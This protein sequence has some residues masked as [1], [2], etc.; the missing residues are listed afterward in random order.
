[1]FRVS[2]STLEQG[3]RWYAA[4]ETMSVLMI[5]YAIYPDITNS[6]FRK[7]RTDRCPASSLCN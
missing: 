4:L 5:L 2:L 3:S 6:A 1:M 7:L